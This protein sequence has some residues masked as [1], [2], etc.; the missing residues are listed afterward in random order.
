VPYTASSVPS[1]VPK[2]KAKEWSEIWNESYKQKIKEGKS[3][4]EA[5]SYAF[6]VASSKAGP[7]SKVLEETVVVEDLIKAVAGEEFL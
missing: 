5:E 4:E 6:A 7:H 2:D 1:Y 3:H